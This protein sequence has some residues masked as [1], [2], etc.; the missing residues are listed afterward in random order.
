LYTCSDKKFQMLCFQ[1]EDFK[2]NFSRVFGTKWTFYST[3]PSRND[4]G[5]VKKIWLWRWSHITQRLSFSIVSWTYFSSFWLWFQS[6][7]FETFFR[8]RSST[9]SA[10][11]NVELSYSGYEF[12]TTIFEKYDL[13]R[14]KAL[15]PQVSAMKIKDIIG[16]IFE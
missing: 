11:A 15:S 10:N 14:D 5:S 9:G 1:F 12:L 6:I 13:D 7:H 16:L 4:L 2:C 3:R 8:L